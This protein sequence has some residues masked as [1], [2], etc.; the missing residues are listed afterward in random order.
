MDPEQFHGLL[1]ILGRIALALEA[2]HRPERDA[3]REREVTTAARLVE[4][5][6]DRLTIER[7]HVALHHQMEA[8][9]IAPR[10]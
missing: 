8:R 10:V 7:E 3:L 4:L 6:A 1:D 9:A 5:T 2:E